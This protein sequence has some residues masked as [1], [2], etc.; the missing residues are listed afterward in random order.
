M[1]LLIAVSCQRPKEESV[2][3]KIDINQEN[4][5]L[6]GGRWVLHG[7]RSVRIFR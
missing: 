3:L 7:T 5:K 1:S 2:V 6:R 4:H